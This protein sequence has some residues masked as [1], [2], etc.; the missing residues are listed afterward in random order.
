MI[1]MP[2]AAKLFAALGLAFL[3]LVLVELAKA[4]FDTRTDFGRVPHVSV[5]LGAALAWVMVGARAGQGVAVAISNGI[6]AC[7]VL[8]A[9]VILVFAAEEMVARAMANR[10][11][12][13][14]AAFEDMAGITYGFASACAN[15]PFAVTLVLGGALVGLVSEAA[16]RR[17][18]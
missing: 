16:G 4:G 3:A 2:T 13:P 12:S 15:A 6:T 8:V 18:R 5:V 7:I 1:G 17:W 9:V 11:N 10:Y 14:V